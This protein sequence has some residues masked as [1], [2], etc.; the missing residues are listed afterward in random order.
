MQ[1]TQIELVFRSLQSELGIRPVYHR[2][3]HRVDAHILV[4]FLAYALQVTLKN[5]LKIHAP[6]LRPAAVSE[7][8][9]VIQ[10]IDVHVPST[11]GRTFIM[12]RYTP[13][14]P[15]AAVFPFR[16]AACGGR[17]VRLKAL[18]GYSGSTAVHSF[19]SMREYSP[20]A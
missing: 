6:G 14:S 20:E 16:G 18:G 8:L 17:R 1:L 2:L 4:A 9:A 13:S 15:A 10:M 3:E 19:S 12:S 7:K 5:R 11:D